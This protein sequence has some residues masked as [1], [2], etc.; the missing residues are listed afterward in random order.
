MCFVQD[1]RGCPKLS[2]AKQIEFG[3]TSM[4]VDSAQGLLWLGGRAHRIRRFTIES[5]RASVAAT[6]PSPSSAA[7]TQ[8]C[9]RLKGPSVT[10]MGF[11]SGHLVTVDSTRAVNVYAAGHITEEEQPT[12]YAK[13]SLSAHRDAVLGIGSLDLPN[14]L[15]AEFFTW[16][17]GGAVNFWDT[18][19]RCRDSQKVDLEQLQSHDEGVL[20]NELKIV[21]AARNM[22][23]FV[24]GDRLGVLRY[25]PVP[26]RKTYSLLTSTNVEHCRDGHG[27]AH[28]KCG[29]MQGRSLTLLCARVMTPLSSPALAATVWFNCSRKTKIH[30]N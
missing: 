1:S 24:S 17:C 11:L 27:G 8:V 30:W 21:R 9:Q 14:S 25:L 2:W 6:P 10:A 12:K 22:D 13:M 20:P 18:G 7:K 5:L 28:K 15:D 3:V 19:G 29:L 26:G 23:F 16:S 4:A